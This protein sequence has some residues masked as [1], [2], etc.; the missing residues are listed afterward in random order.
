MHAACFAKNSGDVVGQAKR[1]GF[2]LHENVL[3]ALA[4]LPPKV[5]H[6]QQLLDQAMRCFGDVSEEV[7]E[8]VNTIS[9]GRLRTDVNGNGKRN[10]SVTAIL[11][12]ILF[13]AIVIARPATRHA[14]W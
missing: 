13:A 8:A 3:A 6:K 5:V 4:Q 2:T 9:I 1:F 11:R 14:K 12:C 7:L 10:H